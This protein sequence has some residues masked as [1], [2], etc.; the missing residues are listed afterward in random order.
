MRK[1][2]TWCASAAL[3]AT[4][5]PTLD[6]QL[7]P[8]HAQIDE[9][10]VTAR[11]REESL[12]NVPVAIQAFSGEDV[13]R[14]AATDLMEISSLAQQVLIH[15]SNS[16]TGANIRIR[17]I[18][19]S[20]FDPGLESS[21]TVNVD[22]IQV[23]RGHIVQQAFLDLESVQVLKG[24]QAL[25]FGKNSPGGVIA[26]S[27][28]RPTETFEASFNLGYEFDARQT[29]GELVLSGP[30]TD[31]VGARFVY[32]GS[33]MDGFL[34]NQAQP[35]EPP[36]SLAATEPF[37]LPGRDSSRVGG[38][39]TH[40]ARLTIDFHPTDSFSGIFRLLGNRTRA[41]NFGHLSV[42]SCT[43]DAP[44]TNAHMGAP[45][46]D[47]FGDCQL[48]GKVSHGSMPE[49]VTANW[50]GA[51]RRGG[52][53]FGRYDGLLGT[54]E[55]NWELEQVELTSTT[56]Y[57][58]YDYERLENNDGT[59]F[60]Q[61]GGL[62]L[63]DH[64]TFSQELR[65][66]TQFPG[67][68][69]AMVGVYYEEFERDSDNLGKI[70]PLGQDPGTGFTNNWA[71]ESTVKGETWSVFG[72]VIVD[73]TDELEFTAGIRYTD[74]DKSAVQGN[75][76]VHAFMPPGFL[77]EAGRILESEF[78]DTNWSP[79]ATLSW[80]ATPDL[81]LYAAYRTGYKAGGFSTNTVLVGTATGESL[82]FEPEEA[83]G[84]EI[85]L[86]S[87][88]MDGRLRLNADVY[89]YRF[90]E[91]QVSAFDSATTSF[92]I[93]NAATARTQGME[94]NAEY[95]VS[96][97]L[98]VYGQLA[99]NDGKYT[100]FPSSPCFS[101]QTA[102]QGCD[103]ATNT[104]DLSGRPLQFA[105]KWTSQAGFDF[106]RPL[107]GE[108][109]QLG[110]SAEASY[111]GAHHPTSTLNPFA[112]QSSHWKFNARVSLA[113]LGEQERWQVALIGRNLTDKW[114]RGGCADKPGGVPGGTDIFCETPR[115]RQLL[116]EATWR[117]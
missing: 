13:A 96:P 7:S 89:R 16:G 57:Y 48:N 75:T 71:G 15:P 76:F 21:V 117:M 101:S 65:A 100:S 27:G 10:L 102:A 82:T 86:R 11:K 9:I 33:T 3:L 116:L 30:L 39:D 105:P 62:Q 28:A 8:A 49:E 103:P 31:R 55:L 93:R 77:S 70:F 99:Y 109:L 14:Y 37:T 68:V 90:K 106:N 87:T 112:K 63:E 84:G 69:N 2:V 5:L 83:E 18:G 108:R 20:S 45:I 44:V 110:L 95:M 54:L 46:E 47:P 80:R 73:I 34:K 114:I 12:Q 41:D 1:P 25:F 107:P 92:E 17:G 94:I 58:Y 24:P 26:L 64:Y 66:L 19:S 67:R 51:N 85:G 56:G 97:E 43:G 6:V 74:D 78:S 32:R 35:M 88:W 23:D 42:V 115:G 91:L 104:Q 60:W 40:T 113:E 52:S 53:P 81:M 4:G 38:K 111:M 98:N 36:A 59:V 22:G 79:E 72:Q 61:L 29:I 50:P